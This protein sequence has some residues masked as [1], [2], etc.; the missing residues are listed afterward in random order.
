MHRTWIDLPVWRLWKAQLYQ[1]SGLRADVCSQAGACGIA[2][3]MPQTWRD[4]AAQLAFGAASPF[5]ADLAIA[6]GAF[7]QARL[8]AAWSPRGRSSLDRND[9][10]AASY[11]AGLGNVLAA[12][13]RCRD[14][15][16][17]GEIA[18]CLGRVTG[19]HASETVSYVANIR[20]W[21]RMMEAR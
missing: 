18:P 1:E 17:W 4:V 7:Y 12:Q 19:A 13:R 11:N 2:Q 9:L 21:W 3:F 15:V 10:G 5:D 8:R 14:A 16:L 20:R 6:A